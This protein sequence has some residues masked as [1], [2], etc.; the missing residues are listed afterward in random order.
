MTENFTNVIDVQPTD[1]L[2]Y[3]VDPT[4]VL[5]PQLFAI[6]GA[7]YLNG[8]ITLYAFEFHRS[9]R[10]GHEDMLDQIVVYSMLLML[11]LTIVS[12]LVIAQWAFVSHFGAPVV[13]GL[14]DAPESIGYSLCVIFSVAA[15][16]VSSLSS[17]LS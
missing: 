7:A 13:L 11:F 10:Q 4:T 5:S 3:Q 2:H 6:I 14:G 17:R 16:V 9:A 12:R 1:Q 8:F 15:N